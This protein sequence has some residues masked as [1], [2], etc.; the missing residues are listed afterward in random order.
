MFKYNTMEKNRLQSG[1]N[2]KI[3]RIEI[4]T[5]DEEVQ[6]YFLLNCARFYEENLKKEFGVNEA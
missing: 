6:G 4:E 3:F 5:D 1:E 2:Q